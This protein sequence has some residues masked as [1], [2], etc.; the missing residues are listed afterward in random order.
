MPPLRSAI[1]P[2]LGPAAP[3]LPGPPLRLPPWLLRADLITQET[4]FSGTVVGIAGALPYV[5]ILHTHYFLLKP[6]SSQRGSSTCFGLILFYVVFSL[7][8]S[9]CT[10]LTLVSLL[11]LLAQPCDGV[12]PVSIGLASVCLNTLLQVLCDLASLY[13]TIPYRSAGMVTVS[14]SSEK[15]SR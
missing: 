12:Y 2:S 15:P 6:F 13:G 5:R 4:L 1:L 3:R 9:T 14:F 7:L 10:R 8:I 11:S